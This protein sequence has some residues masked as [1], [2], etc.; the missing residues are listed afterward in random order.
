MFNFGIATLP[1]I[2]GREIKIKLAGK[3]E[4]GLLAASEL[5][6]RKC[7]FAANLSTMGFCF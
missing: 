5:D 3:E 7:D 2:Q 4:V 6:L 1:R